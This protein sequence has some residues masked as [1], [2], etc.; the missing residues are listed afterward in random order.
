MTRRQTRPSPA[1]IGSILRGLL[2][3][4]DYKVLDGALAFFKP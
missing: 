4:F 2:D 1:N 3:M